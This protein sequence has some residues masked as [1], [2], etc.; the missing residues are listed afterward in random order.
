MDRIERRALIAGAVLIYAIMLL[1]ALAAGLPAEIWQAVLLFAGLGAAA[2]FSVSLVVHLAASTHGVPFY[3]WSW[4]AVGLILAVCGQPALVSLPL[5]ALWL[6]SQA[7]WVRPGAKGYIAAVGWGLAAYFGVAPLARIL[8]AGKPAFPPQ[9]FLASYL[10]AV[11][12]AELL[13]RLWRVRVEESMRLEGARSAMAKLARANLSMKEYMAKERQ[14]TVV[15]ERIRLAREIND[16]LGQILTTTVAQLDEVIEAL[17]NQPEMVQARI[18]SIRLTAR[19]G[20]ARVKTA[21]NA[22]RTPLEELPCGRQLWESAAKAFADTTGIRIVLKI[23]EEFDWIAGEINE[24]IYRIIQEGLANAITHGNA[25]LVEVSIRRE[26][27]L[28]A[29]RISDNGRGGVEMHQGTGLRGLWDAVEALSGE[30]EYRNYPQY[31]FDLGID[32]P[33]DGGR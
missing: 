11:V 4:Q 17:A 2:I 20:M 8:D 23:Q 30:M 10:I 1:R 3:T 18:E 29:V 5:G 22:L 6:G 33:L 15:S 16:T 12:F 25:D 9:L 32:L 19:D 13:A 31:G 7:V 21:I 27:N 26:D 14:F 24:L 28:L